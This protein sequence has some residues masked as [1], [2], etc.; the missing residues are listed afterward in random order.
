[1]VGVILL[2]VVGVFWSSSITGNSIW[3]KILGIG[4]KSYSPPSKAVT[5]PS[6]KSSS[7][8]SANPIT[9]LQ[10]V[11]SN[12]GTTSD[13]ANFYALTSQSSGSQYQAFSAILT[14]KG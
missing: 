3:D 2:I 7:S 8:G 9:I 10:G 13:F 4:K 1:M 11:N 12:W 6:A 5:A 14:K